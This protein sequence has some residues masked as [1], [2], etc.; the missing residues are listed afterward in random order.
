MKKM[1]FFTV[2]QTLPTPQSKYSSPN[3]IFTNRFLEYQS[4]YSELMKKIEEGLKLHFKA[5]NDDSREDT[6][7][8]NQDYI[9]INI[10]NDNNNNN[11]SAPASH[12]NI[13][14][15]R[16]DNEVQEKKVAF[17]KVNA[18]MRNS[19]AEVA[20]LKVGDEI[21]EFGNVNSQTA[22]QLLGIRDMVLANENKYIDIL[23][24]REGTQKSVK[25]R[26]SKWPGNGLLG[27]V[28]NSSSSSSSLLF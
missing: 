1:C 14:H 15:Q 17:V 21:I 27:F 18:V 24:L 8:N 16:G 12:Q 2:F 7:N 13:D 20:G 3:P 22:D 26:P 11:N 25:L 9:H 6:P 10:S 5:D 23:L 28:S 4:D 19:P